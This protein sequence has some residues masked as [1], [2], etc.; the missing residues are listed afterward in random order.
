MAAEFGRRPITRT[1]HTDSLANAL[2]GY[3]GQ[4]DR[5]MFSQYLRSHMRDDVELTSIYTGGGL[6]RK[7][8]SCRPDDMIRS[9]IQFPGDPDGK[10]LAALDK[11]QARTHLKNLLTWTELYRGGIMVMGGL[12]N[13]LSVEE[14]VSKNANRPIT[15]LKVYPASLCLNTNNDLGTDPRSPYFEDIERF[16]IQRRFAVDGQGQL[17]VHASRCIVSKGIP[18]P[19]DLN[20][21]E[22]WKYLYWGMGRFQAI[23]E[24][25]SN[26]DSTQKAFA[27]LIHEATIA[28]Q[29]IPGLMDLLAGADDAKSQLNAVMDTIAR[30]KSVLNMILLP[31]GGEFSR[32]SLSLSGWREAAMI[33]REELAAVAEIPVPR[34]YGIPSSGLGGGGSDEEASK[35]YYAS[36][37]ADQEIK[38]RPIIARLV[39]FVGPSV[40]LKP[41]EAFEFRPLSTPSEKEIAETRKTQAEIDAIY[42]G[43]GALDAVDEIRA[44]RFGGTK[45]SFETRLSANFDPEAKADEEIAALEAQIAGQGKAAPGAKPAKIPAPSMPKAK[46]PAK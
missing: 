5:T 35:T 22:E 27:N 29:K 13:S 45:Y 8:V 21:A 25:M 24:Q 12:D 7:I 43:M 23:F 37:Q 20:S 1:A 16:R 6:G 28:V 31:E 33:F 40:G 3:G 2:V 14:P 19:E 34:L 42:E 38:L 17:S 26:S 41:D 15:F 11:I 32:D 46:V 4:Q 39:E 36:I 18:V 44:S 30:G 10:I 9:W